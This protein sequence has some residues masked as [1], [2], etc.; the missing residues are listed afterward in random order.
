MTFWYRVWNM[1]AKVLSGLIGKAHFN[2]PIKASYPI[3]K[4]DNQLNGCKE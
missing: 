4:L 2:N 3:K 1:T